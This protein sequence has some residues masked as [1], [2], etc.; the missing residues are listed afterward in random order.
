MKDV[1]GF[2][3][4]IHETLLNLLEGMNRIYTS[5]K[6][7]LTYEDCGAACSFQIFKPD[8]EDSWLYEVSKNLNFANKRAL[9]YAQ[10]VADYL[11]YRT[12]IYQV[13]IYLLLIF[14]QFVLIFL[15]K[16]KLGLYF[17]QYLLVLITGLVYWLPYPI[18]SASV[19]FRYSNLTVYFSILML[20]LLIRCIFNRSL[21]NKLQTQ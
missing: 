6:A 1:E 3:K 2:G 11:L 9:T 7:K 5:R 12:P 18:L 10:K 13:W 19:D 8:N 17:K 14:F 16:N 21:S 15:Y 4:H 20:P